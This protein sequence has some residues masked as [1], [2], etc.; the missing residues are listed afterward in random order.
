MYLGD[1]LT[2]ESQLR[3]WNNI[4]MTYKVTVKNHS[5]LHEKVLS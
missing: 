5:E 3:Q 4:V 1:A 2:R